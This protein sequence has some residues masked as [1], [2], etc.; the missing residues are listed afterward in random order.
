MDLKNHCVV[1]EGS[2]ISGIGACH[3]LNQVGAHVILHDS[4]EKLTEDELLA[5]LN[6]DK[7]E[8]IIGKL[9]D[10]KIKAADLLVIS[11]G[12][13]IDSEIVKRFEAADK[14]VWGEIELAYNYEAGKVLA[15]TGTNGKTTTTSLVGEI[16][17]AWGQEDICCRK[18]R[19]LLYLGGSWN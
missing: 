16:V 12:V 6:G 14:P 7:A 9:E 19:S 8:L 13:P 1:V 11:P 4:N 10:E 2:G 18:Y 15:I 3:L 5:K 17:K